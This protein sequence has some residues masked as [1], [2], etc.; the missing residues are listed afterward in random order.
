L[1]KQRTRFARAIRQ[2]NGE[3]LVTDVT[4]LTRVLDASAR[5]VLRTFRTDPPKPTPAKAVHG[6][7]VARA[8]PGDLVVLTRSGRMI[9]RFSAAADALEFSPDGRLLAS[10]GS[11]D[12]LRVWDVRS[13]RPL[14]ARVAHQGPVEGVGF[15]PDGHWIVTAGPIS[16]GVWD[17]T[18]GQPLLLLHGPTQPLH[19]AL[20]T[21]DGKTIV[22]AGYDGTIRTYDCIVC[23]NFSQLV[24]VAELQL[25]LT[26]PR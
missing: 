8:E 13:G 1:L 3:I 18:S 6:D 7:L 9:K 24:H 2:P 23:G 5:R 11:D 14:V 19:A 16:A 4:G 12:Y 21:R 22:T 25:A 17:A 10:G 26:R 20:F 15:S